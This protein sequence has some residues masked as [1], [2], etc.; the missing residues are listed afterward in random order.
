[1]N[2]SWPN[3]CRHTFGGFV[4]NMGIDKVVTVTWNFPRIE[5]GSVPKMHNAPG[6]VQN[7]TRLWSCP[8]VIKTQ[9]GL[10][11]KFTDHMN[12]LP[13]GNRST[14]HCCSNSNI[15]STLQIDLLV[16]GEEC[17]LYCILGA[18]K[19]EVHWHLR[20]LNS[21]VGKVDPPFTSTFSSHPVMTGDACRVRV[22]LHC[23]AGRIWELAH[24]LRSKY[25][26]LE[27]NYEYMW[28][29]IIALYV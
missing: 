15:G 23:L 8:L 28:V 1:M 6:F 13:P 2:K 26:K 14:L 20:L 27:T 29:Y 9:C 12:F 25:L 18:D 4:D 7:L 17:W 10:E 5:L 22:Q 16:N 11:S 19:V 21:L 3:K 24:S